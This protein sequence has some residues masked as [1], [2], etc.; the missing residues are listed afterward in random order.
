MLLWHGWAVRRL[1]C[2]LPALAAQPGLLFSVVNNKEK[3]ACAWKCGAPSGVHPFAERRK[4]ETCVRN[5]LPPP[6]GGRAYTA[7]FLKS[8]TASRSTR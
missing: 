8:G 7:S 4:Q 1:Y 6:S 5:S 3:P 2:R